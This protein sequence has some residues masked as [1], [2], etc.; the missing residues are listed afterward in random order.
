MKKAFSLFPT[1]PELFKLRDDLIFFEAIKNR[2]D[3]LFPTAMPSLEAE[4]AIKELVSKTVILEDITR[5]LEKGK[6]DIL[7][8]EFLERV[9]E[10][11]LPNLRIDILRKLLAEKIMT[12]IRCNP[13]RFS[14]FKERLEK[15]VKAYHAHAI[16][17]AQV[18]KELIKIAKEIKESEDQ[19][20]ALGLT[21]EELAF[22]DALTHGEEYVMSDEQLRKLAKRLVNSIRKNLSIDWTR[23][24]SV[25]AKV[26]AHVKRTLRIHGM[27][28][29]KHPNTVELVMK[30]AEALYKEWPTIQISFPMELTTDFDISP[31]K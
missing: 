31:L 2:L 23:H 15:T 10:L 6:V 1:N 17:S 26:R 20:K 28:P 4:S 30:Q 3:I 14:S 18:M 7:N 5:L 29:I 27:S 13:I 11:E 24:E 12:R 8:E 19:W 21:E 16:S 9:G 25:K 22:Y